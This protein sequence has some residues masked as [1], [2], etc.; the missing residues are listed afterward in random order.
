MSSVR[1]AEAAIV[2]GVYD[3]SFFF[4][5]GT[6]RNRLHGCSLSLSPT[7]LEG[8]D[9]LRMVAFDRQRLQVVYQQL[10]VATLNSSPLQ[11]FG[12]GFGVGWYVDMRHLAYVCTVGARDFHMGVW[13]GTP[14]FSH[15]PSLD[16][17]RLQ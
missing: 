14:D 4:R 13:Y 12:I 15:S 3:V 10:A 2:E 17:R 7:C 6:R 5:V 16:L 9:A 1:A 8:T 11:Q